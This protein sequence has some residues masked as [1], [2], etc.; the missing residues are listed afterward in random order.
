M[1]NNR[2]QLS[3][4]ATEHR[5]PRH[6]SEAR[7]RSRARSEEDKVRREVEGEVGDR[8][9]RLDLPSAMVVPVDEED[10]PFILRCRGCFN[11]L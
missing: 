4:P 11:R 2:D 10:K 6:Q 9:E 3:G 8:R 7:K 5:F 1:G